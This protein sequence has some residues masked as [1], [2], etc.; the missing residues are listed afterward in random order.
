[1]AMKTIIGKCKSHASSLVWLLALLV[2][3]GLLLSYEHFVLW[4]IQEQNL[5]LDT[6]L[7]FRQQMLVPGGLLSY[8]GSFLTQLL[9]DSVLGV[10]V[11]CA[12]WWLLMWLM[13]RTF[14]VAEP[15]AVL[16]LVPV[17]LLLAANVDMGY[18]I[19]PIKLKGWY[20][21]A[22]LGLL[23]V[24]ALLWAYRALS[25]RRLWR[26]VLLVL[27][28]VAGYPLFGTYALAAALLMALWSWRLE[29]SDLSSP[30]KAQNSPR[31]LRSKHSTLNSAI[32]SLL[33]IALVAAVPLAY[34]QFVYYQT[35][36]V[37]LWWTALPTFKILEENS[38][39]YWPYALLAACMVI[40]VLGKWETKAEKPEAK[41]KAEA[42][43]KT[44][45]PNKAEAKDKKN[46]KG[47]K[48]SQ[49][50]GAH[51]QPFSTARSASQRPK[52]YKGWWKLAVVVI[53]LAATVY[54]VQKAWMKDENFHREVAMEY[55]IEQTSWDD[56][57]AEADKQR[58]VPTRA[59]VLM[60]NLALSRLGRQSTEMYRFPKGA[61]SYASPV[62]IPTSML[63]GD[64]FYY[65][66]GMLNDCHHMCLEG[67]VEYGWR[68]EHLKYMARCALLTGDR[69]AMLKYTG[70]LKH[71]LFHGGWAQWAETLQLDAKLRQK[72]RETGPV[73]NMM[74][75]PDMVG[76][77]HGYAENYVMNHLSQMDSDDP[78]F[79]EQCLLATLWKKNSRQF[80]RRFATYLQLHKGEPIP[81]YYQE[82]ACLYTVT[83]PPAPIEVPI[84]E[85]IQKSLQAFMQLLQ[86]YDG[87]SLEQVRSALSPMY[88]DTYF[89]EYFLTDDLNYM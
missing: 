72:D 2:T 73:M 83:Q 89:F 24:V 1:M 36:E 76:S 14:R 10:G 66:Y 23:A 25:A 46:A 64:L 4:K 42:E 55:Y 77:D 70:L 31:S 28:V 9:Y 85:G 75:Y 68:V 16:L 48:A 87:M 50:R 88:G 60:R 11:L 17:A 33:A 74:R 34:Y 79:Q 39:Y 27:T 40:L 56:V 35:N 78:A 20:F 67:G 37:N 71:T 47:K 21:A 65:H 12:L 13:R 61:K 6:P 53:V 54:G 58:D 59:I 22:T 57:L 38:E 8:V 44:E 18:W 49:P 41:S 81:R 51:S 86:Q 84:D 19:Y 5:F 80:W 45:V 62:A 63:I 52:G 82:A 43:D 7:F 15:W 69:N 29:R 32:D 3:A 26:R 30:L